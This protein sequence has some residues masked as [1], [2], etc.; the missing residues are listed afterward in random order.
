MMKKKV[1]FLKEKLIYLYKREI[2][3]IQKKRIQKNN[4]KKLCKK[5]A[6]RLHGL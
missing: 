6:F 2:P 3:E 1:I 5:K 4:Y